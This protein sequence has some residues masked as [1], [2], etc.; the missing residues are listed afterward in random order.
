MMVVGVCGLIVMVLLLMYVI[1]SVLNI[2]WCS[3]CIW[4]KVYFFEVYW[5]IF[6]FGLFF[7]GVSLVI[8]F[9]LF[10]LCWVSDL[11]M[12]IDNVL[13]IFLLL[14][15]WILFWLFYSIV[16]IICVLNCDVFVGVFVVV[17]LFEVGKKGFV[18]YIIM[19]LLY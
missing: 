5:M 13:C 3:K 11:N 4:L 8:S 12:V 19:F 16:L 9:Y 2:I 15:L 7:V 6:M 10:F 17:L 1:D 14:F 18:F